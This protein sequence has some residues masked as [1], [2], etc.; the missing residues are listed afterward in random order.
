ME[1]GRGLNR[2]TATGMEGRK[3]GRRGRSQGEGLAEQKQAVNEKEHLGEGEQTVGIRGVARETFIT[4][5]VFAR[6]GGE[7]GKVRGGRKRRTT[8]LKGG[9]WF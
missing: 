7:K 6:Q 3:T 5:R 9:E 4:R 2:K 1:A 8:P